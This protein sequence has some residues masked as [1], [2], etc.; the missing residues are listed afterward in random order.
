[1]DK[2]CI[3]VLES[4]YSTLALPEG[5]EVF[6][7]VIGTKIKGYTAVHDKNS[8]PVDTTDFLATHVLVADKNDPFNTVYSTYKTTTFKVCEQYNIPFPFLTLLKNHAHAD[9][10]NEMERIINECREK[11]EDLSYDTGWTI[12]PSVR[13]DKDLQMV[14]KDLANVFAINH[15]RDYNIPHWVTLGICKVKTDQY[16]KK[17]G[18][19]EIS[20]KAT[21]IHPFLHQAEAKALISLNHQYTDF[22]YH[23]AEKY[24]SLWDNRI[25]VSIEEAEKAQERV[26]RKLKIAA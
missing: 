24:Q 2:L 5:R 6:S 20:D 17:M 18:L 16:F 13:E 1:M 12:N 8:L 22:A 7:G 9:C 14:L 10:Y 19:V 21:V 26:A 15:H 3:V 4:P 25:T 23:T 11:G